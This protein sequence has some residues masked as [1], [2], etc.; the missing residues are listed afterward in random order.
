M[1]SDGLRRLPSVLVVA[2]ILCLLDVVHLSFSADSPQRRR[3]P[4]TSEQ[5]PTSDED[6]SEWARR[7][8]GEGGSIKISRKQEKA[9]LRTTY[10]D[11][12]N[13]NVP[14]DQLIRELQ[15]VYIESAEERRKL[16]GGR[17]SLK[18]KETGDA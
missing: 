1:F 12:T 3:Q 4:G 9:R 11:E 14:R 10:V 6:I 2:V 7:V 16:T 15:K 8:A 17:R 13:V 5:Q 18:A